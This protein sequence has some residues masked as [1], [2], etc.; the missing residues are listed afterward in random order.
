ML[1]YILKLS[2]RNINQNQIPTTGGGG[3]G[4]GGD[5][6]Q[7]TWIQRNKVV[8]VVGLIAIAGGIYFLSKR[9]GKK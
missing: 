3:F 8:V 4:G 2:W 5:V 1:R 9:K 6:P 7:P